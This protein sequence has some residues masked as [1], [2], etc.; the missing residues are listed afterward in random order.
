MRAPRPIFKCP[1]KPGLR[2]DHHL[3]SDRRR[4]GDT[5]LGDNDAVGADADIMPDLHQVIDM[6]AGADHGVLRRTAV[7]G[8]VGADLRAVADQHAAQ[9]RHGQEA[10]LAHGEAEPVLADARPRKQHHA[11]ADDGVRHRHLRADPA[12]LPDAHPVADHCQ[13]ADHGPGPDRH[14]RA[15]H[16]VGT[17]FGARI[18]LSARIDHGARMDAGTR[19]RGGM[20]QRRDFRPA[21]IRL[22]RHQCHRAFRHARGKVG[23]QN[24]RPGPGRGEQVRVAAIVQ[25][26]HIVR[27]RGLQ[28]RDAADQPVRQIYR[29]ADQRGE[30]AQR[31][32]SGALE[33]SGV[34][35]FHDINHRPVLLAVVLATLIHR[36]VHHHAR[37]HHARRH[38]HR[39]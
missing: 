21:H 16:R 20:E 28:R 7:D 32:R 9:L 23:M 39:R 25:K 35:G 24:N 1:V 26:T 22:R 27:P 4:A 18:D 6:H 37:C 12:V 2:R 17:D 15:D 29:R 5:G 36:R 11:V 31:V 3:R 14:P 30:A 34:T 10:F 8:G 19:R 13:R 33:E 38:L